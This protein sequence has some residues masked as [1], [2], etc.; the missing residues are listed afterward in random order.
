MTDSATPVVFSGAQPTSD[1]L[2]LGNALGAVAQ[3]VEL[4]K[5]H[6]VRNLKQGHGLDGEDWR[7]DEGGHVHTELLSAHR[8]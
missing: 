4:Q 1:S 6:T 3:W 8:G 7:V 2:H 5:D